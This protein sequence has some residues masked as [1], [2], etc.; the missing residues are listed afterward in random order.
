MPLLPPIRLTGAQALL[1]GTLVDAPVT[2]AGGQIAEDDPTAPAI[3]LRGHYLLPGIVDLHG[4]GFERHLT[5]RPSAPFDKAR[6]LRSVAAELVANGVTTA[7]M[8]QSWSWE[9]GFRGPDSAEALLAALEAARPGLLPDL[10]VQI[11][12]ETHVIDTHA[13]FLAAVERHGIDMVIFNNHLPEGLEMAETKPERFAIWAAQQLRSPEALRAIIETAR[14]EDDRVPGALSALAAALGERGV[15]LGSHDDPDA[16]TRAAF[17]A[18]GAPVSEFPTSVAAAEA[19]RA[20]GEPVLMGAPNVVRGG[21]QSGNIAAEG[22]IASGLCTALVSDYYYPALSQ[23]AWA[24]CERGTLPFAE[25]W[26]LISTNPAEVAGLAD[27]G[28][29]DPGQRADLVVVNPATHAIEAVIAGGKLAQAQGEVGRR[30]VAAG[31]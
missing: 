18:M 8:A 28:R 5:P 16:G 10:R 23:A 7:W 29:L 3:D 24:L 11:R 17:R 27:R 6:A 31:L 9:G 1:G 2:L 22:L 25:A 4:D 26:K 20:A 19:A 12:L 15:V 21:S 30:L 13:R 14:E